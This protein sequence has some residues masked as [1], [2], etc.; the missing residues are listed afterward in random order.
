LKAPKGQLKITNQ[1]RIDN[2]ILSN[3]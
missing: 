3:T 2:I 1:R